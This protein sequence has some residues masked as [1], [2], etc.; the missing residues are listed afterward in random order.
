[1][2]EGKTKPRLHL[3][4]SPKREGITS[5]DFQELGP[6]GVLFP[7]PRR[8]LLIF[9]HFPDVTEEEFRDTLEHARPAFILELRASPRFDIGR[10][11]RQ[12]AFQSFQ[13]HNAVYL[14]LTSSLMGK[15]D[16]EAILSSLRRFLDTT[17]PSF[18]RPIAFLMHRM[19]CDSDFMRRVLEIVTGFDS[20]ASEVYEVPRLVAEV[21][22]G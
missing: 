20:A 3:V 7:L 13:K 19:E 1:M 9:I 22:K 12:V 17:R 16:A 10:L 2:S 4:L 6:Q 5:E 18:D 8:G 15:V 21:T 11:N 14:D